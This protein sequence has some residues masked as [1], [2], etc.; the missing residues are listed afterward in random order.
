[1]D[2]IS[3]AIGQ[4]LRHA[5]LQARLTQQ[6]VATD[7]ERTRQAVS[8]WEAGRTLPSVQEFRKLVALYGISA[9]A[10]LFECDTTA[11]REDAI[12]HAQGERP[13]VCAASG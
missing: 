12:H 11:A 4:R 1:M 3:R 9:D 8:A 6:D 10:I 2:E 5:R 13:R 7:F